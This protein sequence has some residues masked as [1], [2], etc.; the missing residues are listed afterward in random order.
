MDY[1]F[2]RPPRWVRGSGGDPTIIYLDQWCWDRL[3]HDRAGECG[4]EPDEGIFTFLKT[5]AVSGDAVFPLSQAHYRENWARANEDARWDTA[6]VMAELSGFATISPVG[7]ATWEAE[8]ALADHFGLET[9]VQKPDPFGWGLNHCMRGV[10]SP[11][12]I[13]DAG[14]GS[15]VSWAEVP[16]DLRDGWA[17]L[18]EEAAYRF[19]LAMLAMR[20]PRLESVTG[21][22]PF[23]SIPHVDGQNFLAQEQ[24][25]ED[26]FVTHGKSEAIVRNSIEFLAFR[27]SQDHIERASASLGLQPLFALEELANRVAD[28]DPS[29]IQDFLSRM[30]IQGIFKELRVRA[31][32]KDSFRFEPSDLLDFWALATVTPFV[33][34]LVT[35]RRTYNLMMETEIQ[36]GHSVRLH[37]RLRDLRLAIESLLAA[38][39]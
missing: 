5:L 31:H 12:C 33:D 6:V 19:E 22:V 10:T 17:H 3:V 20:E 37:R 36:G 39:S 38:G 7:L 13:V 35:D 24:Q 28:G 23:A 27:D 32:L 14:T 26:I 4:G 9:L 15:R 18:E 16:A 34:F 30:P 2:D 11:V 29:A 25:L 21:L 1:E 8:V